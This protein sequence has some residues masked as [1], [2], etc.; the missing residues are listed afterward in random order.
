MVVVVVRRF[1]GF[2]KHL[3]SQVDVTMQASEPRSRTSI[4]ASPSARCSGGAHG[5]WRSRQ[6]GRSA[7][8]RDARCPSGWR[9]A[10]ARAC[11]GSCSPLALRGRA[12]SWTRSYRQV[13]I[14]GTSSTLSTHACCPRGKPHKHH[15]PSLTSSPHPWRFKRCRPL[16][17]LRRTPRLTSRQGSRGP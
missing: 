4:S 14:I 15:M 16:R 17:R 9:S 8:R 13:Q 1:W 6:R 5:A 10:P 7:P 2:S 12:S 3:N 11:G